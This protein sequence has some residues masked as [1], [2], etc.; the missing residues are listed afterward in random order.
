MVADRELIVFRAR[1]QSYP[2]LYAAP[3]TRKPI[4]DRNLYGHEMDCADVFVALKRIYGTRLVRWERDM[5]KYRKREF[6]KFGVRPDRIFEIEDNNQV[7]FLEVDRGTEDL[8]III[9]KL[10]GYTALSNHYHTQPLTVLFTAQAYRYYN[11]DQD[12]LDDLVDCF[13]KASRG[14]QF[15]GAIHDHFVEDPT[16]AVWQSPLGSTLSIDM[17][18]GHAK[19]YS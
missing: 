11:N 1:E 7:F 16:A 2:N 4:N 12:R 6:S 17:L 18:N 13:K 9:E 10:E 19:R 5:D 14:N 3:G 8:D 15:I